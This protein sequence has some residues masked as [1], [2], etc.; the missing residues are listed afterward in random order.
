MHTCFILIVFKQKGVPS[1]IGSG[2]WVIKLCNN[3]IC[4]FLFALHSSSPLY[5]DTWN[6]FFFILFRLGFSLIEKMAKKTILFSWKRHT[7]IAY[8]RKYFLPL[9]CISFEYL[10]RIHTRSW[11]SFSVGVCVY[12]TYNSPVQWHVFHKDRFIILKSTLFSIWG[13][14]LF[15]LQNILSKFIFILLLIWLAHSCTSM[16][17]LVCVC[18]SVYIYCNW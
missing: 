17:M 10:S 18:V 16:W 8:L 9:Y 5:A 6:S 7:F 11:Y 15:L 3:S 1:S 13:F 2:V 4:P 12:Q 14:S